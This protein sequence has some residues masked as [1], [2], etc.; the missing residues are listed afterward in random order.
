M[1]ARRNTLLGLATIVA[2]IAT[3]LLANAD[4]QEREP[5]AG[6]VEIDYPAFAVMSEEVMSYRESRLISLADFNTMKDES[7]TIILDT[8]SASAFAQGHID[9][10]I[11]LNFSDFT[12]EKLAAV[13][14][15]KDTRILIYCNNNFEDDVEPVMLKR[16]PLA[17]NIPTFINLVGYGYENVYELGELVSIRDETV[18]WVG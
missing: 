2:F 9:G 5:T 12:D 1:G 15:S 7:G 13:I 8:R 14:P 10:A 3:G 11:N 6:S 17:L 4:A 16:A 18:N